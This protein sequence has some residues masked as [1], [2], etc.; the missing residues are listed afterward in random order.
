MS[1]IPSSPEI[2]EII[3]NI[4]PINFNVDDNYFP[5][6][7]ELSKRLIEMLDD[8]IGYMPQLDFVEYNYELKNGVMIDPNFKQKKII[9]KIITIEITEIDDVETKN[10]NINETICIDFKNSSDETFDYNYID[11]ILYNCKIINVSIINVH[12][13]S[14]KFIKDFI[15]KLVTIDSIVGITVQGRYHLPPDGWELIMSNVL[16]LTNC[17]K[18]LK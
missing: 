8:D 3:S 2:N 18:K 4:N 5:Y 11:N 9:K 15:N 17:F 14:E 16:T 7:C 13:M 10:T 12:R 1:Q 6:H